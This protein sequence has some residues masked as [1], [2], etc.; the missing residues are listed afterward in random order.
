MHSIDKSDMLN[1]SKYLIKKNNISFSSSLARK[2]KAITI[3][4]Y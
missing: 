1:I 3:K 4:F 2:A